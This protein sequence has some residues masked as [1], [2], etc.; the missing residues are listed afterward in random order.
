MHELLLA[1]GAELGE[2]DSL[3]PRG[4]RAERRD[5]PREMD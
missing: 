1:L 4:V 2:S 5:R 3:W